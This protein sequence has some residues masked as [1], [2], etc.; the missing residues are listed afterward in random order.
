MAPGL[1]LCAVVV[2]SVAGVACTRGEPGG[3]P[4]APGREKP[5][6]RAGVPAPHRA[7]HGGFLHAVDGA[8]V[9]TVVEPSGRVRVYCTNGEGRPASPWE[10]S[11]VV[12]IVPSGGAPV[13]L[14][15][16]PD[17]QTWALV[18]DGAPPT[19]PRTDY[20]VEVQYRGRAIRAGGTVL[21]G[22]TAATLAATATQRATERG[23]GPR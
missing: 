17:G 19:S 15:L 11:G 2:L 23:G 5:F 8:S 1:L 16:R 12:T 14:R 22:G 13:T 7:L 9:E 6:R 3:G 4:R 18:G 20:T 10:A 21:P